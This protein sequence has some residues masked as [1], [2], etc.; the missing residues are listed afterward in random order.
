MEGLAAAPWAL[1]R[2][3]ALGG[4]AAADA[5]AVRVRT[6]AAN[7]AAWGGDERSAERPEAWNRAMSEEADRAKEVFEE[8][9]GK[10][11]RIGEKE[12]KL[13]VEDF[14][15]I[16]PYNAQVRLLKS[17]LGP[18]ARVGSVDKFQGQQAPICVLSMCSSF[19]E[20]GHRGLGF[21]LDKNRVN[22]ALSRAQ[23]LAVVIADPRIGETPTQSLPEM[24]L[25]NLFMKITKG[26][27]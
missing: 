20:Y 4:P 21:I 14:L 16:S 11:V 3:R 6:S 1:L 2:R 18:E 27:G 19:G 9:L 22:V 24:S 10:R 25:L 8:L 23:V 12:R 17:E 13:E 15:F 5:E 7:L 26:S